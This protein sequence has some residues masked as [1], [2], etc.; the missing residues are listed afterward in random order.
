MAVSLESKA[1]PRGEIKLARENGG[2]TNLLKL[3]YSFEIDNKKKE[4]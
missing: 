4:K 1:S 2:I 3:D